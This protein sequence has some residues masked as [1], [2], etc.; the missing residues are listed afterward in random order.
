MSAASGVFARAALLERLREPVA[1]DVIVIGGGATGLGCA[2]D[3]TA[4]GHRVLLLEAHDFAKGTSSRATKLVHGGLRYLAQGRVS[5]V[6]ESLLE[7]ARLLVN[8]SHL[9]RPQRFVVPLFTRRERWRIGAGLWLYDR[10]AGPHGIGAPQPI[11]L[12]RLGMLMP[13]LER[14]GLHGALTYWDAQF[15]DA[16]LALALMRTTLDLGGLA[17]NHMAVD[18][19]RV[20][21]GRVCGVHARDAETGE[22]FDLRARAVINATGVWSDVLRRSVQPDAPPLL[23]TSQGMHIVVPRSLFPGEDALL[24]PKTP[25]GRVMF[26]VPWQGRVVIG[27]TDTPRH[28]MPLE[29]RPLAGEVELLF[30]SA[31]PYFVRPPGAADVLS[32]F[33]G[34]R[35]LPAS[36][37]KRTANLS[38]RHVLEVLMPGLVT[39]TGG[40]WT[41]Y[42]C[43][44]EAAVNA[45]ETTAGLAPRPCVTATLRIHD[46]HPL[47]TVKEAGSKQRFGGAPADD[48]WCPSPDSVRY[49]ARSLLAR[50]VEDVL[51]RRSRL[52]FRDA[53]LAAA[54]APE[55]AHTLA[56]ELGRDATWCDEQVRAF[57]A[58]AHTYTAAGAG[59]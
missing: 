46:V 56:A 58:L 14:T 42:R 45:A 25:D 9:V 7:R 16:G 6:R 5:L 59:L 11:D 31:A 27:T 23:R 18:A 33:T 49:A 17:L 13:G 36:H 10:L 47:P 57:Q 37:D 28:D 2:L 12:T 48:P 22:T 3:A 53:H 40:K 44:A 26:C 8:A 50:T 4:R 41:T 52:L 54:L 39:I 24:V 15:D 55:V 20:E 19:L 38:R 29:P 35:P 1:W 32:V 21:R 51:A 30:R 34:L 43:M